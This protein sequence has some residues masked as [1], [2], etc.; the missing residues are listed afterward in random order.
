M[1]ASRDT[2]PGDPAGQL[3][4]RIGVHTGPMLVGNLGSLQRF[5]YTA[6]GDAVNLAARIEG[7]NKMFGTRAI[8]SGETLEAAGRPFVTRRLGRVRVVGREAPVELFELLGDQNEERTD[9]AEIAKPFERALAC[10]ERG[11]FERAVAGFAEV[12]DLTAG[13]DGP[14]SYYLRVCDELRRDGVD[15]EWSGVVSAT[16]K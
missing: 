5:D 12:L 14:S 10:F 3:R 6:I 15:S 9:G 8:T 7:I 16:T 4:T 11:E 1:E 13:K 2:E